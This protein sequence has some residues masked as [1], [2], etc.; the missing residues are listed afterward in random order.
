MAK[1]EHPR[2]TAF[3]RAY[4]DATNEKTFCNIRQSA[5]AAGFSQS[6]AE[7]LSGR[8]NEPKWWI[9]FRE[10]QEAIRA[11]MLQM[12]EQHFYKVLETPDNTD[13]T[14]RYKLKQRTA[15]FISE[16]VGKDVYSTR[17]EVTGADGRRLFDSSKRERANVPLTKLFKP[18]PKSATE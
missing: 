5:L 10:S 4:I 13:N 8:V 15:E 17:Q 7:N 6:Y 9:Q 11:K 3:K 2:V 1:A 12:S 16:R 18:A 14:E